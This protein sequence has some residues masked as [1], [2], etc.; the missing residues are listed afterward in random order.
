MGVTALREELREDLE[1]RTLQLQRAVTRQMENMSKVLQETRHSSPVPPFRLEQARPDARPRDSG[2]LLGSANL[3]AERR[4]AGLGPRTFSPPRNDPTVE[5]R[6]AA[7]LLS[8]PGRLDGLR[9]LR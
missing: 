7:T 1:Q 3:D 9:N 6:A 4:S 2:T 5:P 8:S